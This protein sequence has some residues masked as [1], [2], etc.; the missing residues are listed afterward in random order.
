MLTTKTQEIFNCRIDE[1]LTDEQPYKLIRKQDILADFSNRAA[2]SDFYPVKKVIQVSTTSLF[3]FQSC[4]KGFLVHNSESCGDCH[5][6]IWHLPLLCTNTSLPTPSGESC[7]VILCEK[8]T[9]T[10][11][12]LIPHP[13]KL[14]LAPF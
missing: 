4:F 2:V 11:D 10:S 8:Q 5:I 9:L 14:A 3:I 6:Q 12:C 1:D 7:L 13:E